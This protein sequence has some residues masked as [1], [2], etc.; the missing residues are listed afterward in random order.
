[1]KGTNVLLL[2]LLMFSACTTKVPLRY[3]QPQYYPSN[4]ETSEKAFTGNESISLNEQQIESLLN[5]K[6]ILPEKISLAILVYKGG[7]L[8]GSFI[9]RDEDYIKAQQAYIDTLSARLSIS[10][11]IDEIT[12]M[13]SMLIGGTPN[14]IQSRE[15]AVRMQADLLLVISL[16][17][18]I[19]YR[20]KAFQK[21]EIKAFA[22]CEAI[23][24]DVRSGIIP[25]TEILT[26]E[27]LIEKSQDDMSFEAS[28]KRAIDGAVTRTLSDMGEGMVRFLNKD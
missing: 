19:Y 15:W 6:V 20:Q 18:D 1:M 11:K 23:L 24:M 2:L 3:V 17:S 5:A 13:P 25:H 16:Q 28:R 27:Y 21:D 9:S 4:T 10:E 12:I 8:Q 14:A 22:T 7:A 26:R